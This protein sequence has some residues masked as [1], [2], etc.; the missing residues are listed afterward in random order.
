[1]NEA[2]VRVRV[3]HPTYYGR[4]KTD[5]VDNN[6]MRSIDSNDVRNYTLSNFNLKKTYY[7]IC[8][9]TQNTESFGLEFLPVE[10]I[11]GE[12]TELLTQVNGIINLV[13]IGRNIL[14]R[15]SSLNNQRHSIEMIK[16]SAERM[17]SELQ[18]LRLDDVELTIYN[19]DQIVLNHDQIIEMTCDD[20]YNTLQVII[21]CLSLV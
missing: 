8:L 12:G 19:G 2:W 13:P 21:R 3:C 6:G 14:L 11:A 9:V 10:E 15:L 18:R 5:I 20:I 17:F 16:C 4:F 1:M 7:R